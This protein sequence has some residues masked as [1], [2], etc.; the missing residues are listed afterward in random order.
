MSTDYSQTWQG[1]YLRGLNQKGTRFADTR[2][3]RWDSPDWSRRADGPERPPSRGSCRG[4]RLDPEPVVHC[5]PELLF[6]SQVPFSRLD[7]DVPQE[8]LDLIQL[9]ARE[10]AQSGAGA[11]KI[12]GASFRFPREPPPTARR[13]TAPWATS[14]LPLGNPK[15]WDTHG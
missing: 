13:P 8:K 15:W 5:A 9:A 2:S 3:D 4:I 7:R 12:M 6:A 14:R 1:K 11:P 10:V